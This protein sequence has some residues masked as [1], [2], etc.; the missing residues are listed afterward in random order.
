MSDAEPVDLDLRGLL[1]PLPVIRTAARVD[2]LPSGSLLVARCTDPG[3][4]EDL[5]S[6]CRMHGHA[7]EG[8]SE[9]DGVIEVR[10]RVQ[11]A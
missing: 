1:C 3:V 5:P 7:I 10:I 9:R 8:I 2:A 11:P 4:R 6:W